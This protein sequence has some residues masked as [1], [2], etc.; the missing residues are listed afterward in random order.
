MH[1]ALDKLEMRII[2]FNELRKIKSQLPEG[3]THVIADKLNVDVQ[4]VRN[5]F[6][7]TDYDQGLTMGI[8]IEPGPDGSYVTL[9]DPKILDMAIEIL[10]EAGLR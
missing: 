7:G 2:T 8:H 4:T 3:S 10:Q 5:Y 6:G 9:D 1:C